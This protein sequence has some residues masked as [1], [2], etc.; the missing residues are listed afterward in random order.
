GRE[1]EDR[2]CRPQGSQAGGCRRETDVRALR[3]ARKILRPEGLDALRRRA[4]TARDRTGAARA[5][6][7]PASRRADAGPGAA[8][9]GPGLRGPPGTARGRSHDPPGRAERGADDRG[10]R[11]HLR[12]ALGRPDRLPRHRERVGQDRRLRD[13]VYRHGFGV[14]VTENWRKYAI[15]AVSAACAL[16]LVLLILS[17]QLGSPST[18]IQYTLDSIPYATLYPLT[19]LPL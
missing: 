15:I 11:P 5:A 4:A 10:R 12:D 16:A 8:D 14:G 7:A 3:G 9:T 13:R 2:D 18:A 1:P 6:E 17:L 19:P